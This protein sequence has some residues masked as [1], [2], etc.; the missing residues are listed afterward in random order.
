MLEEPVMFSHRVLPVL[1]TRPLLCR[2]NHVVHM[3]RN[4]VKRAKVEHKPLASEAIN[5]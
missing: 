5:N 4:Y 3:S 1:H 2:L